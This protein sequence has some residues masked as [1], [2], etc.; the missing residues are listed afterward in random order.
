[1]LG[2]LIMN[3]KVM[4]FG[5]SF[6]NYIYPTYADI[7][8]LDNRGVSGSGNERIFYNVMHEIKKG[9]LS[10]HDTPVIQWTSPYRFDY[11]TANGWTVP[12]GNI[13]LSTENAHIWKNIQSWYNPQYEETKTENYMYAI[14]KVLP[15]SIFLTIME[16]DFPHVY[17]N[18]M[19]EKYVG[20]YKFTTGMHWD[21]GGVMID[22]HPTV[23]QHIEIAKIIAQKLKIKLSKKEIIRAQHTH[24]TICKEKVFRDYIL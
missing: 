22:I 6:T 14:K 12:D 15:K 11:L 16:S 7:L 1:M 10:K 4:A 21:N 20:N 13:T 2:D 17:I 23:L 18:N 9:N 5:C 8:D 24:T 3:S 19:Q